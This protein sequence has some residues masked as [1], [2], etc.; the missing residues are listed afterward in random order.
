MP[1]ASAWSVCSITPQ[2]YNF[3]PK[4]AIVLTEK[5][6]GRRNVLKI[7]DSYII[8][9]NDNIIIKKWRLP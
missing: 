6:K 3:I 9:A 1:P 4:T 5:R 7:S 8:F 2:S